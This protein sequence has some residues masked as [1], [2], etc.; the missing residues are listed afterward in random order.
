MSQAVAERRPT[1][2]DETVGLIGGGLNTI[3]D[4]LNTVVDTL[5]GGLEATTQEIREKGAVRAVGDAA[6]DA[7]DMVADV[8]ED[9]VGVVSG[10]VRDI[11]NLVTD[12]DAGAGPAGLAPQQIATH[13]S[14]IS[15]TELVGEKKSLGLRLEH[16]VVTNFTEPEVEKFGWKKGD[17]IMAVNKTLVKQQDDMLVAIAEAKAALQGSGTPIKFIVERLGEKPGAAA[18]PGASSAAAAAAGAAK[19]KVGELIFTG[20]RAARVQAVEGDSLRVQFQDDGSVDKVPLGP[21]GR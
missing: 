16:K 5:D 4:G 14:V 1:I 2:V 15:V 21:G 17:V 3:G 9:V 11:L 8:V 7:V 19:P 20:G 6:N 18:G 13:K 10:G 12:S